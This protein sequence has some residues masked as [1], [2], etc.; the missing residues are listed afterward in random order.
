MVVELYAC[1][2]LELDVM[3][4]PL[5]MSDPSKTGLENLFESCEVVKKKNTKNPNLT[6]ATAGTGR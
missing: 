3:Y 5:K 6:A 2:Y 4:I 1:L